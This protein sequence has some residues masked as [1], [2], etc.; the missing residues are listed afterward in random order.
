MAIGVVSG[1]PLRALG[2][3]ALAEAE[4][5][6]VAWIAP[7]A[8]EALCRVRRQPPAALL[9]DFALPDGSGPRL[10]HALRQEGI[11]LDGFL[12]LADP[13]P[14]GLALAWKAGARAV[15]FTTLPLP[16]LRVRLRAALQGTFS[17]HPADRCRAQVWWIRF[18]E[19]WAALSPA[20]GPWPWGSPVAGATRRS[21]R[22]SAGAP[23]PSAPTSAGSCTAW[24]S[25]TASPSASGSAAAALMIPTSPPSWTSKTPPGSGRIASRRGSSKNEEGQAALSS[26]NE[27][28]C[29]GRR[30]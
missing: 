4:G 5:F 29:R 2:L 28:A 14:A 27:E 8:A 22:P 24:G 11:A 15:L 21:P 17:W 19:P 20:S 30:G 18:G 7:T 25:P 13:H 6:P 10:L 16:L 23:P 12:L 26:K 1:C 9:I 3:Q